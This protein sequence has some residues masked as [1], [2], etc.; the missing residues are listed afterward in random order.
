MAEKKCSSETGKDE[1]VAE[2]L[3]LAHEMAGKIRPKLRFVDGK[4]RDVNMVPCPECKESIHVH[5]AAC[6]HCGHS[7]LKDNV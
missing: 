7:I 3:N 4:L 5:E 6:I 1:H 2:L